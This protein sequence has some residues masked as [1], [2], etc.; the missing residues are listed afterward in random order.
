MAGFGEREG[1]FRDEGVRILAFTAEAEDGARAMKEDQ[2]LGFTVLYGLDVDEMEERYGLHVHR[3]ETT[4]LQPAQVILDGEG[5]VVLVSSSSGA[6]GRLDAE[7][8]LQVVR[9]LEAP[10]SS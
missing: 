9:R 3:G 5:D 1:E 7:D 8:A 2:D 10:V 6:V 4:H